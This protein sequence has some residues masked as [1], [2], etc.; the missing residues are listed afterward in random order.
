MRGGGN[1]LAIPERQLESWS[2]FVPS[3]ISKETADL[4]RTTLESMESVVRGKNFTVYLQGSYKNDTNLRGDS[5]VDIVVELKS[6]FTS[7][8]AD[9]PSDQTRL[10]H[11]SYPNATYHLSDFR[12]D[13]IQALQQR[14]T[15]QKVDTSGNKAILVRGNP[16]TRLDADVI[17]CIEY[18]KYGH[19]F[20]S[21]SPFVPGIKFWT[22]RESRQV[23]NFPKVHYQRGCD[24][25]DS[26]RM[27]FKRSVRTFKHARNKIVGNG[28]M[29]AESAPSFLSSH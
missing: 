6:T 26:T 4:I 14:Y 20:N 15:S 3:Q 12:R 11:Q 1:I 25:H 2:K 28:W 18:R 5:D 27:W 19:F 7:N 16:G 21:A 13:V 10:Y 8:A 22:Q 24:K 17:V 9:L 29:E 23:I